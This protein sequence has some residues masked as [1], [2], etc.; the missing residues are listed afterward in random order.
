MDVRAAAF[1][2]ARV[3]VAGRRARTQTET[4]AADKADRVIT[5]MVLMVVVDT[6]EVATE[7]ETMEEELEVAMVVRED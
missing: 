5:F 7:M 6:V 1:M 2:E 3:A 4:M